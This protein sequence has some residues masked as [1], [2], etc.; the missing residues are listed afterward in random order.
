[1]KLNIFREYDIRGIVGQELVIEESYNLGKAIATFLSSKHPESSQFIIGRDGRSHSQPIA[2]NVIKAIMDLGF[3]VIDVGICPTPAVYFA[4]HH[5]NLPTALVITAS[6]NPKE[7][8]GVKI[9]GVWGQQ[10][11][12]IKKIFVDQ[13]FMQPLS[14]VK[15]R[16]KQYPI[17]DHYIDYLVNHFEHLQG[18][19]T[20]AIIDCGNGSGGTVMPQLVKKMNWPNIKLLFEEVDGNFP[21][22]EA[23]PTVPENM[24]YV[25]NALMYNPQ[26]ELGMGLDGDC[27]RMNPMTRNG[28]LVPGDQVLGLFAKPILEKNPGAAVVCDIKSSGGVIDALKQWGG[29]AYLAPSGYSFIKK[30]MLENKALLGGELSCHFTFNDRYF[31]YDDGIYAA[32]RTLE[33]LHQS[34]LSLEELLLDIPQKISSPEIRITCQSDADKINIMDFGRTNFLRNI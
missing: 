18:L 28:V 33:L 21:N 29:Q 19:Q 25:A 22:H 15:G 9:W 17:V 6:H 23:D 26:L 10:I 24:T 5:L 11:T 16:L 12:E 27:D 3:D 32:L 8:N 13:A 31:G 4:V 34:Q 1:M 2:Q 7:Y 30:A 14:P 20:H